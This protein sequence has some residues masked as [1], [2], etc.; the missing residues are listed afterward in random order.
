M[1]IIGIEYN[2]G[3]IINIQSLDL[4]VGFLHYLIFLGLSLLVGEAEVFGN[5]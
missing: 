5:L 2:Y 4:F 3:I 1:P